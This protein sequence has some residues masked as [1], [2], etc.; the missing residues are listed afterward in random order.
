MLV[1]IIQNKELIGINA[2]GVRCVLYMQT[3]LGTGYSLAEV[4]PILVLLRPGAIMLVELAIE[5][6]GSISQ[7]ETLPC[8]FE[9]TSS[10]LTCKREQECSLL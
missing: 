2:E 4:K 3:I 1:Y 7:G 8:L 10:H 5:P 9:S 6:D